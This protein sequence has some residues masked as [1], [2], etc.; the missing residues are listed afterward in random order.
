MMEIP[1]TSSK[2][3][4]MP[5]IDRMV[6]SLLEWSQFITDK[7]RDGQRIRIRHL[8]RA[9]G[10]HVV[11]GNLLSVFFALYYGMCW[12]DFKQLRSHSDRT[13]YFADMARAA[14]LGFRDMAAY[15]VWKTGQDAAVQKRAGEPE[16]IQCSRAA[17]YLSAKG[18]RV[19]QDLVNGAANSG[20]LL[21][22]LSDTVTY[23]TD[24]SVLR[25]WYWSYTK[26]PIRRIIRQLQSV[27]SPLE[28]KS[29]TCFTD[30]SA[31]ESGLFEGP[32]NLRAET[33]FDYDLA[34]ADGTVDWRCPHCGPQQHE[35]LR[36]WEGVETLGSNGH[37]LSMH[38]TQH[39]CADGILCAKCGNYD[40][41]DKKTGKN[42]N[43]LAA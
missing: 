6:T 23:T 11:Y 32:M 17:L 27:A 18:D 7:K 4:F 3:V 41:V 5:C 30:G 8:V 21:K 15:T 42:A 38:F 14:S 10:V 24:G 36:D 26:S 28:Y 31:M 43:D 1:F 20:E 12:A 34:P 37:S 35:F 40:V 16:H 22:L 29:I 2:R 39:A 9:T 25:I 19:L 33:N 13:V